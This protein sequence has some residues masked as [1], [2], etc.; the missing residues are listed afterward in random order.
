MR[1]AVMIFHEGQTD[2]PQT[3]I[4]WKYTAFLKRRKHSPAKK[5]TASDGDTCEC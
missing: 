2:M 4:L 3:V 1:S 5:E